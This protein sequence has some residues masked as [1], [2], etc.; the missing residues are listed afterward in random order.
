MDYRL[1]IIDILLLIGNLYNIY[2]DI[3]ISSIYIYSIH[4]LKMNYYPCDIVKM[5]DRYTI[6]ILFINFSTIVVYVLNKYI[7]CVCL[8][9]FVCVCVW[10]VCETYGN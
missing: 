4:E 10:G 2:I 5:T 8:Y 6:I 3:Y 9:V 1:H 7:I